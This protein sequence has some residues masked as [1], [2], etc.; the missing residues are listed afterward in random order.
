MSD[1]SMSV[2]TSAEDNAPSRDAYPNVE[3]AG[4]FKR[5]A[6][7]LIDSLVLAIPLY[8]MYLVGFIAIFT[9]IGASSW[10][11]SHSTP[12]DPTAIKGMFGAIFG[13]YFMIIL[14]TFFGALLYFVLME[15]GVHGATIGKRAMGL[16]VTDMH[17]N[18]LSFMQALGRYMSKILSMMILGI[19]Y[20][21]PLFNARHQALHDM[22]AGTLVLDVGA[23]ANPVPSNVSTNATS[24]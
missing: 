11:M 2:P 14:V 6:A 21:M 9:S 18:R 4:F 12:G 22:I 1:F 15:S 17:G 5:Y 16:R 20:L 3:Y 13:I 24:W 19:G 10:D 7:Y 23:P 8:V